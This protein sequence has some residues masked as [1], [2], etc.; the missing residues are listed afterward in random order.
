MGQILKLDTKFK[1]NEDIQN[2]NYQQLECNCRGNKDKKCKFID[3]KCRKSG[4]IYAIECLICKNSPRANRCYF[5]SS[6]RFPKRRTYEHH[7]DTR[8]S[9]NSFLKNEAFGGIDSFEVHMRRHYKNEKQEISLKKLREDTECRVEREGCTGLIGGEY[10]VLCKNERMVI[11]LNQEY[12]I[13]KK[14]ELFAGCRHRP[15]LFKPKIIQR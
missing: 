7:N 1:I 8:K 13:N 6:T 2:D 12:A 10:C 15:K 9:I 4:S 11:Y 5:G 3:G 14:T